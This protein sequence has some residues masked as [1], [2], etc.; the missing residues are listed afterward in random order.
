VP[1]PS[2]DT[3]TESIAEEEATSTRPFWSGLLTFGLVSI[4]VDLLPATRNTAHGLRLLS[5]AGEQL[6]RHYYCPAHNE[7]V[8]PEHIVRGYETAKGQ[9]IAVSD[10]ELEALD[11]TKSREI[12]LRLFVP[13]DS[14]PPIYF[15]RAYFL[16]PSP[17]SGKAYALLAKALEARQRI[18]IATFVMRDREYW[19]AIFARGGLLRAQTLRFPEYVRTASDVGLPQVNAPSAVRVKAFEKSVKKLQTATLPTSDLEDEHAARLAQLALD[20]AEQG[21]D[22]I[23]L[24]KGQ[25]PATS[26][27]NVIDLFAVLKQRLAE[28]GFD[29]KGVGGAAAD[30]RASASPTTKPKKKRARSATK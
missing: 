30:N 19:V 16:V 17:D 13:S 27:G 4:P 8:T 12:D 24:E 21:N 11:P 6:E 28:S 18:G 7:A 1:N 2:M 25:A 3:D 20:K 22:V 23:D 5:E 26:Q 15:E 9:Y 29:I 10:E 14:L